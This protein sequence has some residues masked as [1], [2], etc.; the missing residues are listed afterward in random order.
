MQRV[1]L[2]LA[3]IAILAVL[4]LSALET[5]VQISHEAR[6]LQPGE[7]V[8]IKVESTQPL[9][10]VESEAFGR[11]FPFFAEP[12]NQ[13][14]RGLI[15]IDLRTKSGK[16]VI[17]VR[18]KRAG[19][20]LAREYELIVTDKVFPVR[21]LTVESKFVNP[22]KESLDRIAR[23]SKQVQSIFEKIT[24]RKLWSGTFI[25]PVPGPPI[26]AFGKRNIMNGQERSPHS[27]TDFKGASGTPIKAPNGGKVVLTADLYYSGN[28]VI[29][30]HGFG[31]YSYFAHLSRFESKKG[32]DVKAG[33][34]VGYVG[35]TGRVTGS[36]LH[37]TV[38]LVKTRVDPL[39]LMAVTQ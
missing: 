30:D 16:Y 1:H 29:I 33:D 4:S 23:E 2:D 15:G 5:E 39:S 38:R 24:P 13:V 35:A 18:S 36:H 28:T 17:Q 14:W 7:V 11:R 10:D 27:G 8:L 32:D 37:W 31:L 21:R 25:A 9:E 20:V 12:G 3:V 26:S 19:K 34:I 6:S 22:P